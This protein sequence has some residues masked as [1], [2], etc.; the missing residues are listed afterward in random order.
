MKYLISIM[1]VLAL[2]AC[3]STQTPTPQQTLYQQNQH[4]LALAWQKET[5]E[6]RYEEAQQMQ[7]LMNGADEIYACFWVE[8]EV[9]RC[10]PARGVR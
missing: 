8:P 9:R 10:I 7:A 5:R 4:L 3:G 6:R 2:M 1:T